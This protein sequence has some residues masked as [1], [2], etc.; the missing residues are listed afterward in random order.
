M[1][2]YFYFVLFLLPSLGNLALAQTPYQVV[3]PS[4]STKPGAPNTQDSTITSSGRSFRNVNLL[5]NYES[6]LGILKKDSLIMVSPQS[7]FED[8]DE[9]NPNWIV[10]KMPPLMDRIYYHFYQNKLYVISLFFNKERTSFAELYRKL[11]KRYGA[12]SVL[13]INQ[14]IWEI[15][16]QTVIVLDDLPSL[17]YIDFPILKSVK[18]AKTPIED[19]IENEHALEKKILD[20]L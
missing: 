15:K 5:M 6:V 12:A 2:R 9:E 1:K 16:D 3:A 10:A 13:R 18:N 4:S 7:D 8:F 17:K 11:K 14:A 20:D 19:L